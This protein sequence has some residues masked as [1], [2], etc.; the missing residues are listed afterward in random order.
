MRASK[1]ARLYGTPYE[2]RVWLCE[3]QENTKKGVRQKMNE[4]SKKLEEMRKRRGVKITEPSIIVNQLNLQEIQEKTPLIPTIP[5]KKSMNFSISEDVNNRFNDYCDVNAINKSAL[6]EK[7]MIDYLAGVGIAVSESRSSGK[8][9]RKN[10]QNLEKTRAFLPE[11]FKTHE[12]ITVSEL[13]AHLGL[14]WQGTRKILINL[15]KEGVVR[16][17]GKKFYG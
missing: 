3:H 2:F 16:K 7:I 6:I 11:W 9:P 5:E 4:I 15:E 1:G 14:T 13:Q 12:G 10:H 17:E 8:K